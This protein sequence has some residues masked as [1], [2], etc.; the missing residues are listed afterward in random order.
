MWY[1]PPPLF[2]PKGRKRRYGEGE[3]EVVLFLVGED[4]DVLD[5]VSAAGEAEGAGEEEEEEEAPRQET[6]EHPHAHVNPPSTLPM[7]PW[8]MPISTSLVR[9]L[10]KRRK[11]LPVQRLLPIIISCDPFN[12]HC[13]FYFMG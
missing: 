7:S 10:G 12:A 9:P 8:T 3:G 5:D 4:R 6:Q 13:R 2:L 1:G 11:P